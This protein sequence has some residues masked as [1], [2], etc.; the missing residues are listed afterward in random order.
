MKKKQKE[1]VFAR[2]LGKRPIKGTIREV[3]F[4]TPDELAETFGPPE[5]KK[6]SNSTLLYWNFERGDCRKNFTL[7]VEVPSD[8][9]LSQYEVAIEARH[10]WESFRDWVFDRLGDVANGDAL[11]VFLRA[12][13]FAVTRLG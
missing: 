13:E 3:V 7:H 5:A 1:H 11:P 10:G 9:K 8:K 2:S 4:L 12:G 6:R